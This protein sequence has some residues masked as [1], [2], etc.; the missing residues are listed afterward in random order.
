MVPNGT[1]LESE[2]SWVLGFLQLPEAQEVIT[3][4]GSLTN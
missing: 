4:H 2:A 3:H 1:E